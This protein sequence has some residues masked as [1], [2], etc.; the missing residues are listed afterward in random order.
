MAQGD[1]KEKLEERAID[2]LQNKEILLDEA[3][4]TS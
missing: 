3:G 2:R 1:W 4:N